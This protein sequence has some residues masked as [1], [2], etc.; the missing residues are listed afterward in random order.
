[1][2]TDDGVGCQKTGLLKSCE[3]FNIL[4]GVTGSVAAL[5]LPLLV[6]QLL[7]LPGVSL[8]SIFLS[9]HI[10]FYTFSPK[11][12][13]G[14][15]VF[16]YS[17]RVLISKRPQLGHLCFY[18]EFCQCFSILLLVGGCKSGHNRTCQALL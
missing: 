11:L 2:Q 7:Q 9:F 14:N 12:L 16:H 6:S 15:L 18:E 5:K 1:M 13:D 8:K 4:V 3:R 10:Y 17:I